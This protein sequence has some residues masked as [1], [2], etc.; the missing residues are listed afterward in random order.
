MTGYLTP[1]TREP[2]TGRMHSALDD[3]A[4]WSRAQAMPAGGVIIGDGALVHAA[5]FGPTH[6]ARPATLRLLQAWNRRRTYQ[7]WA[8]S[9]L[10]MRAEFRAKLVRDVAEEAARI[11]AAVRELRSLR[12]AS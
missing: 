12:H 3:M 9:T 8:R 7:C 5:M 10:R 6:P 11:R 4:R 1:A 2:V